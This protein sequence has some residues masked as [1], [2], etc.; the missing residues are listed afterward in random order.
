MSYDPTQL[1]TVPIYRIRFTLQDTDVQNEFLTDDE[2]VYLLTKNNDNEQLATM[3][4]A[5]RMLAQFAQ[6]TRE[7]EG[8]IEVY[9][10]EIFDQWKEYLGE[11]IKDISGSSTIS[12]F[13]IG[14]VVKSEVDRVKCDPESKGNGYETDYIANRRTHTTASGAN[15]FRIK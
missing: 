4:A 7:R 14:G 10:N 9:G 12:T 15:L 5:R 2:L 11:L 1:S 13:I 3:E 6:Y 8:L